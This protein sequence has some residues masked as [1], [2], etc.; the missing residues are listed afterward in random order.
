MSL[1]RTHHSGRYGTDYSD[2]LL[3]ETGHGSSTAMARGFR[4]AAAGGYRSG[5]YRT[6]PCSRAIL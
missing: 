4:A 1:L 6:M 3:A 2:S 5:H